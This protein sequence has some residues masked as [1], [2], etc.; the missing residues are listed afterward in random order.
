MSDKLQGFVAILN[1][2]DGKSKKPP[3]KAYS[4]Y[5]IRLELEDGTEYPAWISLG[6]DAPPFQQGDYI[7]IEVE[8]VNGRTQF[9]KGTGSKP[10]NP[11]ARKAKTVTT[12]SGTTSASVEGFNRQTNPIDAERM[13]YANSRD[14]AVTVVSLLL[15]HKALPISKADTGAGTAQ[16]FEEIT[17]AIDKLT[18]QYT[19]D[20]LTQ[21]LFAVVADAGEGRVDTKADGPIPPV[22]TGKKG[23]KD[24]AV[25]QSDDSPDATDDSP[26]GADTF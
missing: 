10:K 15:T 18:V 23:K 22:E 6:F 2:K 17:A 26:L 20:A 4:M 24:A 13:T 3:Y 12:P 14:A 8:E 21:R 5:S 1:V 11:P 25:S 9:V 19:R 16:R 7:A